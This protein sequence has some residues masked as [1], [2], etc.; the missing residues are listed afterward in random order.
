VRGWPL[1]PLG[2]IADLSL[3]KMLD[4]AKNRGELR[5]YLRNLNVRWFEFDLSDVAE[6]R[7]EEHEHERYSAKAGDPGSIS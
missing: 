7:F 4:Q 2:D 6:M 5:P 3:G 1:K